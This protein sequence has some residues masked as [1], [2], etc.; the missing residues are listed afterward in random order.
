MISDLDEHVGTILENLKKYDLEKNTI[1]IFTSDNG[2][3]HGSRDPRFHVG[4]A[5][6]TFFNSTGGLRGFKGSC[7]EGGIRVP[8]V[9][10]WPNKV[11]PGSEITTPSY[12]PDWFPTLAK[13]A[14]APIQTT[15]ILDG[16]DL[17]SAMQ[18]GPAPNRDQPMIWEFNGY[19]GI[20]AVRDGKWKALR[21]NLK[22]GAQPLDW[23]LYNLSIDPSES[24]DVANEHPEIVASLES[25]FLEGRTTE[26]DFPVPFLDNIKK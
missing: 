22:K 19:G 1:V 12:F 13:I 6:S 3:T 17:T 10:R 18:A 16:I 11:K 21:R 24:S 7:Y 2:P 9:V 23:E 8:C 15:Q 26:P 4:G 14:E 25:K 20:V 5:A